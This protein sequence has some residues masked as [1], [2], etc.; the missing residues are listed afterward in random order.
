MYVYMC[1]AKVYPSMDFIAFPANGLQSTP[2]INVCYYY[3]ISFFH[4]IVGDYYN[5]QRRDGYGENL[6]T[7]KKTKR[8]VSSMEHL[9]ENPIPIDFFLGL[10]FLI[11]PSIYG[12]EI[13]SP[14]S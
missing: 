14:H 6:L 5:V 12:I 4:N 8:C 3:G 10:Y 13:L 7:Q 11:Q 2:I 1:T 9:T